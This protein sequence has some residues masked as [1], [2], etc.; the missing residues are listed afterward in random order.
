MVVDGDQAG[1]GD[2]WL[3]F[4]LCVRSLYGSFCRG[5]FLY[6]FLS[7]CLLELLCKKQY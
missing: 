4:V 2:G 5:L 7:L 6:L 1:V 3:D